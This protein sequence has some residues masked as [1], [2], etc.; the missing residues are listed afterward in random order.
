MGPLQMSWYGKLKLSSICQQART[1][2]TKQVKGTN[3][4]V[5]RVHIL[6]RL[7]FGLWVLRHASGRV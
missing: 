3:H 5:L 7:F 4:S 6:V 1:A 2:D